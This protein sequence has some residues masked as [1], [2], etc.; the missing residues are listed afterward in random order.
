MEH[1][2]VLWIIFSVTLFLVVVVVVGFIWFLPP[3]S[4]GEPE[5]AGVVAGTDTSSK[6][7]DP[8]VWVRKDQEVPG[9]SVEAAETAQG[10]G[11]D[12]LLVYGEAG[13]QPETAVRVTTPEKDSPAT[14]ILAS[15]QE[16]SVAAAVTTSTGENAAASRPAVQS[17]V[18][19]AAPAA[20]SAST[21]A[22]TQPA[23]RAAVPAAK[24]EPRS[25]RVTQY[26]IQAG[27]FQSQTRAEQAQ[28]ALAE[29]GWNTRIVS[30]DVNGEVYFRVRLGPFE[31]N[32]EANKFLDWITD[33]KSF[34]SSYVSQV[35]TTRSVN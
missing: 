31:T 23:T 1:Q 21:P 12:L 35:Y 27:S 26:W 22:A 9:L 3:E 17:P 5:T 11:E 28:T 14:S 10:A 15:P 6:V 7:F 25:E 16:K 20:G 4:E 2:K 34:E 32:A 29:K 18:T 30:R 8:I 33:I 24:P 19:T 13:K